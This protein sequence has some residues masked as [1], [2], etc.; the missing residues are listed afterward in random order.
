MKNPV[1]GFERIAAIA[2]VDATGTGLYLAGAALYFTIVVGL[3]VGQVGLGLSLAGL[4]GFLTAYPIGRVADRL[5]AK[6]VLVTLL[7]WRAAG[8]ACYPLVDGY[9]QFL[10]VT[11]LLGIAEKADSP[12]MQATVAANAG[13]ARRVRAMAIF[14]A[15]RNVGF[16]V[17][18]LLALPILES[19]SR[20]AFHTVMV[21]DAVS[22]V[23]AA[24]LVARLPLLEEVTA[25]GTRLRGQLRTV[26]RD[27]PFVAL[28]ALNGVL[29]IH[30]TVLSIALPLWVVQH[31]A[32]PAGAVSLLLAVNT[33]LTVL[34]QVRASRGAER[35]SGAA[36]LSRRAGLGLAVAAVLMAVASVADTA[37]WAFAVL[38]AAIVAH[39]AGELWQSA[40][41]WGLSYELSPVE[42]R[43][44]RIAFFTLGSIGQAI[45][46]PALIT[47]AVIGSGV[48][49]WLGL[50]VLL[51]LV[52]LA[53]PVVAGRARPA[54]V[55]GALR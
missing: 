53:V 24:I 21:G 34:F 33:V 48:A 6:R 15:T 18:V 35:L 30:M 32:A 36:I 43:S 41:G 20:T 55:H 23:A 16:T 38:L 12:L 50:A 1:R 2:L 37:A 28:T 7:L 22:F 47:G 44:S 25:A 52:S 31:T 46:G 10:L 42:T 8:M 54:T 26:L 39:T 4:C 11:C 14:N 29:T 49:G 5:G 19:G 51:A 13:P 9:G 3:S 17:G 45:V 27:R 40:G